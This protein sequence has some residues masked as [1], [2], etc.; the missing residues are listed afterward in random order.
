M[1]LL[2]PDDFGLDRKNRTKKL[3]KDLSPALQRE[4]DFWLERT[5]D[6]DAIKRLSE[7]VGPEEAKRLVSKRRT[8]TPR[9]RHKD[10]LRDD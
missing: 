3:A 8:T 4:I 10:Q 5:E 7:I 6:P 2:G 9:P 1:S